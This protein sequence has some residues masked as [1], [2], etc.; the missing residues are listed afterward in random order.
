LEELKYFTGNPPTRSYPLNRF[1]PD[2]PSGIVQKWLNSKLPL[3]ST[4]LDPFGTSPQ[5]AIEAAQAGYRVVVVS[6]NPIVS[7]VLRM[8]AAAPGQDDIKAALEILGSSKKGNERL[9]IHLQ[10]LYETTCPSCGLTLQV[11]SYIWDRHIEQPV[12]KIFS[13]PHCHASGDAP[14]TPEDLERLTPFNRNPLHRAMALEKIAGMDDP[15]RKDAQEALDCYGSRPLYGL[16]TMLNRLDNLDISPRQRNILSA[17]L[18][19]CCD[20]ASALWPYPTLRAH[21]RQLT[22]PP[23]YHEYNL[24]KTLEKAAGDLI[25]T[26]QPVPF[27]EYPQPMPEENGIYLIQGRI[28]DVTDMLSDSPIHGVVTVIPR[29]NQAFWTLSAVW[30]GW[31]WGKEFVNPLKHALSRRRYDWNWH[32]A[33]LE[34]ALSA[35]NLRLSD[36]V[37][38]FGLVPEVEP[39]FISAILTSAGAAHLEFDG[40]A[41]RDKDELVQIQFT[42]HDRVAHDPTREP[43]KIIRY[44]ATDFLRDLGE[45]VDYLQISTAA[46]TALARRHSL[47]IDQPLTQLNTILRRVL[48]D[49]GI[50]NRYEES[51][52]T[53]EVGKWW[54]RNPDS[55]IISLADRLE[56]EVYQLLLEKPGIHV[57]ELDETLCR[58]FRGLLTPPAD[59]F[60][61]I[62]DSYTWQHPTGSGNLYLNPQDEPQNRAQ[63]Q[64]GQ[65]AAILKLGQKLGYQT[66]E[67]EPFRWLSPEDQTGYVFHVQSKSI[68]S[69][70]IQSSGNRGY[71]QVIVIPGSR[72]NLVAYKI[73]R[74]PALA[75]T[76]RHGWLVI[77]Y[78]HVM[79][80]AENPML[81]RE[82]WEKQIGADP[83]EFRAM[84]M[85]MF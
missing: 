3:G 40:L 51:E 26:D 30:A 72:A 38:I 50:F 34:T 15:F 81:T 10:S 25:S 2:V 63:D 55:S 73:H 20:Q 66:A 41:Y 19:T 39:S 75:E 28:R 65:K 8:L 80:L 24:W 46:C 57:Q 49:P 36:S 84:Q 67:G 83:P 16:F 70:L 48:A 76:L 29:P 6:N 35:L 33:A 5:T 53:F 17:L 78:R 42:S 4:V 37:P 54:L 60:S 69:S 62:L 64:I 85:D 1:I 45:P 11:E 58:R 13:C 43:L 18:L 22:I 9:E 27:A 74:N 79:Q 14:V 31:L 71:R 7:F 21:P 52:A 44:G 32:T 68:F 56:A 12:L 59:L 77:K 61:M 23:R 82:I 47:L